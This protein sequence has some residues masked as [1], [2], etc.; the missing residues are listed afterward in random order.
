M[1]SCSASARP[2]W[3]RALT[4]AGRRVVVLEARG[5]I[6]GRVWT[7]QRFGPAPVERGAEFVHGAQVAT[8]EWVRRAG[9]RTI[10]APPWSG[11]RI[12]P[13]GGRLA[14]AWLLALRPGLRRL[15]AI[16]RAIAAYRGPEVSLAGWIA[17]R[18][19]GYPGR[20]VLM[21]PILQ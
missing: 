3:R 10:P 6:G 5:R 8:W 7:G 4:E 15:P 13:G 18:G 12:P 9:L 17:A 19:A 21:R 1:F 11:R 16:G 2:G 20:F 14:G